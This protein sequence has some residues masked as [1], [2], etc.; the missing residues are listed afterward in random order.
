MTGLQLLAVQ[1]VA[2]SSA[3]KSGRAKSKNATDKDLKIVERRMYVYLVAN[4][5]IFT[6]H[7]NCNK[8]CKQEAYNRND[9][10]HLICRGRFFRQQ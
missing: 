8:R 1:V 6:I 3:K 7:Q 4:M 5:I 10:R 9:N 2:N